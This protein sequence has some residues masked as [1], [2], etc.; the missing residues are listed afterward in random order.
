MP[1]E[2]LTVWNYGDRLFV[3][4][5]LYII[6]PMF[7][8]IISRQCFHLKGPSGVGDALSL[9][10]KA[11]DKG[12]FRYFMRLDI[13][14]YYASIDRKIL[15]S[16]VQ[17]HFNDPRMLNY[18]EQVIKIP[19]LENG[20]IHTPTKGIARRSSLSP[21]FGALYLSPLDRAF[22]NAQGVFCVRY[23]DDL[24]ILAK[25]RKQFCRAKKRLQKILVMLK[26]QLSKRKTK[27]GK[28]TEGFH[29][30]GVDFKV[31]VE[32]SAEVIAGDS[33][34]KDVSA[35]TKTSKNQVSVTL[36]A[37]SAMRALDKVVCMQEDVVHPTKVQDYLSRWAS[38]WSRRLK[39]ITRTECLLHWVSRAK[40][41]EPSL[42]W[43]GSGLLLP[44]LNEAQ[45]SQAHH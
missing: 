28:L 34:V 6:K 8:H 32:N 20:A 33:V 27:M 44:Q 18:L 37:R 3:R 30:L 24:V 36:H 11:L 19:T 38:W 42:A 43:L 22:E 12:G 23:M 17:Q 35:Q 9:T 40:V 29:F 14:G 26:L 5:L 4:S 1:D 10:Q 13:K 39:P 2:V 45:V 25:T 21:F 41:K 7:K 31:N 16:Q 15:L